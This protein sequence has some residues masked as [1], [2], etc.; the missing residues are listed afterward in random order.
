MEPNRILSER[1]PLGCKHP[2][3]I[4]PKHCK[5]TG[6]FDGAECVRK[7]EQVWQPKNN[8]DVWCCLRNCEMNYTRL[9]ELFSKLTE[10]RNNLVLGPIKINITYLG[11]RLSVLHRIHPSAG[12]LFL[13]FC[14][15]QLCELFRR[16]QKYNNTRTYDF[17]CRDHI[18]RSL[19]RRRRIKGAGD[20]I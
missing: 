16:R 11:N 10:Q 7:R 4:V 2:L 12:A 18:N 19:L 13:I 3:E 20:D 17:L 8:Y 9:F 6:W 14:A 1:S 5:L 15:H